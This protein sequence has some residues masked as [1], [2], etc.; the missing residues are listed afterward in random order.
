M[1]LSCRWNGSNNSII[2]CNK[3]NRFHK[4][5][6]LIH[7][8]IISCAKYV[9]DLTPVLILTNS[10][11][12]SSFSTLQ[13]ATRISRP[14]TAF[15]CV[16]H[17]VQFSTGFVLASLRPSLLQ[18]PNFFEEALTNVYEKYSCR[19]QEAVHSWQ[20]TQQWDDS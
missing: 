13:T 14:V 2:Y 17:W 12:L 18:I 10:A 8:Y 1:V 15:V 5:I 9:T 3:S 6:I 20:V 11:Y 16:I 7:T 4:K 19:K